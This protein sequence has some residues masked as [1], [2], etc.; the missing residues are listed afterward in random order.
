MWIRTL[1]TNECTELLAGHHVARLACARNGR[2]YVVPIYYA[3]AENAL[4][5]FSIPGKKIDWMRANPLVSVLVESPL[6]RRQWKS[7][8]ADGRYEELPER[9]GHKRQRDHAW[10]L[11]NKHTDWWEPGALKPATPPLADDARHIF[12][13]IVIEELSGREAKE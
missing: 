1:S 11:L 7:V 2:P 13:R 5:A 4:Y 6:Q 10:S 9:I 3:Y 8:I 12:F